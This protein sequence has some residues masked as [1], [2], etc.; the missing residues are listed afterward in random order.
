MGSRLLIVNLG[1][2]LQEQLSPEPLLA[3]PRRAAWRLAWSSNAPRYG[4]LG[5]SAP[6][7]DHG[8]LIDAE[9]AVFLTSE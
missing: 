4:G 7:R 3:P 9:L 2:R 5:T 1:G 8:W 6:V